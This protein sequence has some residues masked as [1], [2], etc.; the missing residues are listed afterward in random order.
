MTSSKILALALGGVGLVGAALAQ[1]SAFQYTTGAPAGQSAAAG[2]ITGINSVY[3]AGKQELAWTA[4]FTATSGKLPNAFWLVVSNGPDPKGLDGQL[5][6][7]YFDATT[8]SAPK[9]TAYGYNGKN[10]YDSY[11]DGS[12]AAGVQTPDRIA[13]SLS[14]PSFAK[15]LTVKDVNGV[16]TLGFKA[17]VSGVNAYKPT[18]AATSPWEGAR[19]GSQIGIWFHPIANATTTYDSKGYLATFDAPTQGYYDAKNQGTNPVPEPASMAVVAIGVAG[20]LR[21]RAKRA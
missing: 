7:F 16:R 6:I 8:L 11:K 21:R 12:A 4:N 18:N 3:D 2:K 1:V 5:A 9:L 20:L 17:D 19:Y 10:G 15:E 13:T 14:T